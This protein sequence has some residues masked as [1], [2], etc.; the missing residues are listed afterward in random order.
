MRVHKLTEMV[1]GW[2]VGHFKPTVLQTSEFE[3]A[4]KYYK[5]GDKESRHHHKVAEEI[6]VVAAGCVRMFDRV[7]RQG[8]II[9]LDPG[10]STDFEALEDT[11]TVVVKR[12]SVAG[13]K[14]QD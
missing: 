1:G 5:R 6:T 7:F 8:E 10:D 14:Y 4:V 13:D 9:H 2:F 11:I 12:P 3:T